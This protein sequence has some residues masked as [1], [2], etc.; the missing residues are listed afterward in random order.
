MPGLIKRGN[1]KAGNRAR[2]TPRPRNDAKARAEAFYDDLQDLAEQEEAPA[3]LT[4]AEI[5][6]ILIPSSYKQYTYTVRLWRRLVSA[7][8]PP[9]CANWFWDSVSQHHVLCYIIIRRV[10][11]SLSPY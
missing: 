4:D 3:P 8:A 9:S 2:A 5:K 6:N 10:Y 7:Q 1:V 11:R